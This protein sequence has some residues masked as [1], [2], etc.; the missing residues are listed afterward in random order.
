GVNVEDYA[1]S[2]AGKGAYKLVN[3]IV[4]AKFAESPTNIS[5]AWLM[6][7]FGHESKSVSNKFGF[8]N[9][10]IERIVEGMAKN[11]EGRNGVLKTE[12]KITQI[13]VKNGEVTKVMYEEGGKSEEVT[14]DVV[15]STLPIPVLLET[16]EELPQDYEATL[17]NIRYK[18][19]I[20]AALAFSKRFSRFYWLNIMDLDKH[21]FV[22]IFEHG[23]LNN[24]LK[25]PSLMYVV[26]Y[27][28]PTDSFWHKTDREI[29]EDF[30]IHL[31]EI[32]DC[33]VQE[34]LL[35]WKVHR[36]QYS[37]PVFV[38]DYGKSMPEVRSPVKGLYIGGISRVYPRDRYMGTAIW[39][40][41]D[42]AEAVLADYKT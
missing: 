4:Q 6:S 28:E 35:W 11:C 7:R 38:P 9:G 10:G 1:H 20:C 12:A 39:T 16:V 17:K 26:K 22:G 37:T 21:P 34:D 3:Y 24:E 30:L 15:V 27:L 32:F 36:A 2:V 19:S 40:G 33:N 25:I 29:V 8:M 23:H 41:I 31:S 5:A 42:A 13:V 18:A 14:A